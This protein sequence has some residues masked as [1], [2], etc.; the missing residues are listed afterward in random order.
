MVGSL[1]SL[2]VMMGVL[3]D[4]DD[5]EVESS[6]WPLHLSSG[7]ANDELDVPNASILRWLKYITML[8]VMMSPFE[9]VPIR[10]TQ[11]EH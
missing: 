8:V 6:G 5:K 3:L 10:I 4:D 1:F 7:Y 9:R 2:A 11:L